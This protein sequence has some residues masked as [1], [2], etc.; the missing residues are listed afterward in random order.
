M[1]HLALIIFMVHTPV[2]KIYTF[3]NT[4]MLLKFL[5][6][7]ISINIDDIN[8]TNIYESMLNTNNIKYKS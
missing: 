2:K 7:V 6:I 4:L 5:F 8:R 3:L 1:N